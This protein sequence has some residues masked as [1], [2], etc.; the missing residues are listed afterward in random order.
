VNTVAIIQARMGSTRLPG[1]VL[2]D[3]GGATVLARVVRRLERSQQVAKVVVATTS[4]PADDEIVTECERLQVPSFR[5]SEGDVLDRYYQAARLYSTDAVVRITSDC[6]VID[7]TLVDQTIRVFKDKRAD[8]ASNVLPRIYPRGLDTEVFTSAALERA[9]REAREPHEREHVTPYLY[10]HPEAF[11]LASVS[12]DVN[13]SQY[14]WTVDT[15]GDLSL[16]R[17]LYSRFNNRDDFHWQD[18]IALMEREPEL[19]DLN[20]HVLQKS[21]RED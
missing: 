5:G 8:Y 1:K 12:G 16:L 6:P 15:P 19:A 11:R 17:A 14:R 13:Y 7:P 20:S 3:L 2:L 9:W 4:L 21:L 18:V 10:E